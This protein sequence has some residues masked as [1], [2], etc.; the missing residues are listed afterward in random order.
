MDVAP[1]KVL[2]A[3]AVVAAK[4][5]QQRSQWTTPAQK[6]RIQWTAALCTVVYALFL[7]RHVWLPLVTN[8]QV[9]QDKTLSLLNQLK[10]S[11]DDDHPAAWLRS[12]AVYALGMA[13]WELLGLTT[14]PVETGA[15][16]VFG[17][18][19]AAVSSLL[20]KLCGAGAAY[21]LG[22]TV[23]QERVSAHPAFRESTLFPLLNSTDADSPAL[24]TAFLLKF[25]CFPELVKNLG[26]SLIPAVQPWMFVLATL[27]HGGTFTLVWTWLGVDTAARLAN[28][29]LPPN[30]ALQV[31]LGAAAVVGLVLTPLVMA[32]WVRDLHRQAAEKN[33]E[34]GV[35]GGGSRLQVVLEKVTAR[36]AP[37]RHHRVRTA[38]E[39]TSKTE[40]ALTTLQHWKAHAVAFLRETSLAEILIV[41]ILCILMLTTGSGGGGV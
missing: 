7:Q 26:S 19:S 35:D 11:S 32:W 6:K 4:Q 39:Q 25:S 33:K 41:A 3:G 12:L 18:R 37:V 40:K 22:R 9:L 28:E 27:V 5:Q 21:A 10:P 17:F 31:T 23:L 14:I 34:I 29:A 1:P 38:T 36:L 16:M 24:R 13:S 30:R 2:R 20:G 8:K 15:G